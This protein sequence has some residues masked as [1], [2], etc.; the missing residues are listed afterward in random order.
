[1]LAQLQSFP[2][3]VLRLL[4][5]LA[6][7]GLIAAGSP[8]REVFHPDDEGFELMKGWLLERGFPLYTEIWSDQ[9]PLHTLLLAAIFRVFG[10]SVA[11][12]RVVALAF[13]WLAFWCL[14]ELAAR[15]HGTL[16]AFLA[17]T[18]LALASGF[19]R[20]AASATIMLPAYA[21]ALASVVLVVRSRFSRKPWHLII[22]G[23]CF[24]L[25]MQIKFTP[26][27]LLPL[28]VWELLRT[29][30][31][32]MGENPDDLRDRFRNLAVWSGG[33]AFAFAAIVALFPAMTTEL[34]WHPH[35]S[36]ATRAA[37]ATAP[38]PRALHAMLLADW[39]LL[40]LA[41]GGLLLAAY[42]RRVEFIP[43]LL[44]L[45][46]AYAAHLWQR[47]FWGYYYLHLAL[48]LAWLAALAVCELTQW[49]AERRSHRTLI[50][51]FTL[52]V[53]MLIPC[54][55]RLPERADRAQND[56]KTY[57]SDA[58]SVL[59][60]ILRQHSGQWCFISHP[61]IAFQ[62]GVPVPPEA[63]VLSQKRL[64]LGLFT[65]REFLHCLEQRQPGIIANAG[66]DSF[67][68]PGATYLREHYE[69]F[70]VVAGFVLHRRR[71]PNPVE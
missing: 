39:D 20:I 43:P 4:L 8:W 55:A 27:L 7:T 19:T 68:Q 37:F 17:M 67:G 21:L 16:A 54:A 44:L 22:G 13:A 40:L 65:Q 53:A 42:R 66:P 29:N 2:P 11:A 25:A 6:F 70:G 41:A 12:A 48:P 30:T 31:P 32:G 5:A 51:A 10:P 9:P 59:L 56:L 34:L 3:M 18:S 69:P 36:P 57:D 47:P 1:M 58:R 49:V 52:V 28:V 71:G 38:G 15:R 60:E 62:A 46:T 45:V 61:G 63:V 14:G 24:G 26:V 64:R 33:A 35:F 23:V 50:A